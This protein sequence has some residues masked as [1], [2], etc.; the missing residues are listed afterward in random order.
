MGN[1]MLGQLK[2][3]GLLMHHWDADGIC[4]ASLMLEHLK[5]KSLVN[6]T[7]GLGNYYLSEEELGAY[8]KFDFVIVVDMNLPEDNILR[9]SKKAKVMIFDN[10]L[11]RE[12]KE[13][14]HHNPVIKGQN[15]DEWPS[16]SWIVN[17]FLGNEV[18][19]FSLLG[20][21]G[22]HEEKIKK[23]STFNKIIADF[24]KA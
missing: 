15:P 12:N 9:L 20:I 17:V 24:C 18:N 23:N 3:K 10:H 11:G 1:P 6:K 19:L 8:S 5:D 16:T 14:F 7:P 2:G 21:V 13:V 22:D 4:S